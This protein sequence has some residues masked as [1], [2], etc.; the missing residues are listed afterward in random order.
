M[1]YF[2]LNHKQIFIIE[3]STKEKAVDTST[4]F[5]YEISSKGQNRGIGLYNAIEI[6]NRYPNISIATSSQVCKF[7]Q[8]FEIIL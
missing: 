1:S 4:L 6:I 5:N 7:R 3:N 2:T 8:T